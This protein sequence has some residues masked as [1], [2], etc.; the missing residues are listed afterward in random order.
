MVPQENKC[1]QARC[2]MMLHQYYG[3]KSTSVYLMAQLNLYG[4]KEGN[5]GPNTIKAAF[6]PEII[7][8]NGTPK[9]IRGVMNLG[10]NKMFSSLLQST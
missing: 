2:F 1:C 3:E 10:H 4:Y 6:S 7:S 8:S 5:I 9:V